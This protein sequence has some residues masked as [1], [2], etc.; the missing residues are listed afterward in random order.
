MPCCNL[1]CHYGSIN[2]ISCPDE[3]YDSSNGAHAVAVL[4]KHEVL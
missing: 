1:M 3:G 2:G 4:L